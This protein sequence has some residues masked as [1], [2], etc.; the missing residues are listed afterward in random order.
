[1]EDF[2]F[3]DYLSGLRFQSDCPEAEY[4]FPIIKLKK[5]QRFDEKLFRNI[6]SI[7]DTPP[8]RFNSEP[9]ISAFPLDRAWDIINSEIQSALLGSWTTLFCRRDKLLVSAEIG[10]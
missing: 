1:M 4:N 8:Y 10:V 5:D 6:L 3:E 2:K 7:A 9:L